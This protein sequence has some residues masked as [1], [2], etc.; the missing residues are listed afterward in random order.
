VTE[1]RREIGVRIALGAQRHGVIAWIL[2]WSARLALTGVIGGLL[3]ALAAGRLLESMLFDVSP[4]DPVILGL[5]IGAF[6][7]IAALATLVPA[8]RATRVQP[9]ES[10]RA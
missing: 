2:G 6:M 10:L 4:R 5:A 8:L 3:I 1:R 9:V 7:A